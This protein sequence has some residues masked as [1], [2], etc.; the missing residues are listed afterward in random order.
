M[1]TLLLEPEIKGELVA[2]SEDGADTDPLPLETGGETVGVLDPEVT[3]QGAVMVP[4]VIEGTESPLGLLELS[5][6]ME[7]SGTLVAALV[8]A[9]LVDGSGVTVIEMF[10][11]SDVDAMLVTTSLEEPAV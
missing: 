11:A 4:L 6:G 7:D 8:S 10:P 3:F 1:S 5:S 9:S 2:T